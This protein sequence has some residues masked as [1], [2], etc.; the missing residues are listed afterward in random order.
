[1]LI[2]KVTNAVVVKCTHQLI[3]SD[4]LFALALL[5]LYYHAGGGI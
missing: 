3:L 5:G 2:T 4:Q 1:M